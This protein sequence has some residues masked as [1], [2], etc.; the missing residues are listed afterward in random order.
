MHKGFMPRIYDDNLD[1]SQAYSSYFQTYVERDVRQ[2]IQVNNLALFE[3]FIRLLA[4]RI[5]Q[6]VNLRSLANHV[7]VSST[8]LSGWLSI[9]EASYVIFTL[10]PYY[11]NF[12]KR[13][14]KSPKLYF[15]ETGLAAWLLGIE[16]LDQIVRDPLHG[17]LFENMV[18]VDALKER[19]HSAREPRLYFWRDNNRNEMDLVFEQQRRLVP[20]EIKSAMT[21]SNEFAK[22]ISWFNRTLKSV[23]PGYVIYAG[24]IERRT[25]VYQSLHFSRIKEIMV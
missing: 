9:L 21:W 23:D 10:P 14:I 17:N 4:G 16:H 13:L 8:T 6:P 18:V 11:N 1:P 12:G 22:S 2:L 24:D 3:K 7:G 19:L 25:E 20:I 15:I 5:G